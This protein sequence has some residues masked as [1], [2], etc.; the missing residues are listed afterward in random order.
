MNSESSSIEIYDTTL[1][2]GSQAEDVSFSVEDKIRIAVKLDELGV[3]FIEGGWPGANPKDIE[4]FQII[5]STP[6]HHA[7][8]VAF[9]STRKAKNTAKDDPTLEA[10]LSAET[11][12][13]TIFGKSW[14]LHVTEAL[15]TTL[16]TNVE[17]IE[18][19]IA[20]LRSR[21]RQVFYDAEHFFDG[22]KTDADY[23]LKTIKAAVKAGAERIVLCDTN[24][25]TMPWEIR[26]IFTAAR[27]HCAVPLGIH[28]HND[29]EMGVAN[30]LVAVEAGAIQVQGTINGI[31]ERCGNANLCSIMANLEL[32]M[33]RSALQKGRLAHLRTISH[34][35]A[36]MANLLPN[37]RQ[38]YVGEAAFAH[39]GG[40]HI[41]AVQKNPL[42]YEHVTP[43]VVG[44]HRRVL[45]SDHSGRSAVLGKMETFGLDLPQDN[46]K[47][48]ELLGSLKT[49]EYEG[50]QFEGAEGSFELL[51]RKAMGT[52]TPSFELLGCRIIVE[53]RK[54]D[55]DPISEA[56]IMVKV[57]EVVEHTAAVGDGPVNAL[58]HALRKALE[59]FYPQLR[60]VKLLD[61][62]VRVLTGRHG[63]G[64]R[65]RVL[66]E[67]G[68]QKE[69]W[70]TVGVSENIIEASWQALADSIEYKL[71]R[72]KLEAR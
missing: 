19:S 21:G 48:Q 69:K 23:A 34:F 47:V 33:G 58:D 70:G 12:I 31:G 49:L 55:E 39:K 28:A 37:K 10:L 7:K 42:T 41:H 18:D 65:V 24:G 72:E 54:I 22:Y 9:G 53:K 71:M 32:K 16:D 38:P 45:I 35:V 15:E 67:S 25:G 20:F 57:G 56:T 29:A 36:E 40:V 60:E 8:I 30:S 46:P 6:L 52:H 17:L 4:F 62:K 5:K 11:E 1:R 13:V 66:I 14:T 50:Y 43:D 2:D 63:T 26:E 3:H 61:Y 59:H 44:N 51:V 27:Q 64:S 68:D